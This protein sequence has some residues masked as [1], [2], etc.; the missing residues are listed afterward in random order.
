MQ[1][2]TTADLSPFMVR[3]VAFAFGAIWGSFFNVAIHRWPRGLSVVTPASHCPACNGRIP[4]HLNIPI[5]SFI[6]LRGKTACCG[7]R[8][9]PRYL[10]VEFTSAILCMS[11]V[12]VYF[13]NAP[14]TTTFIDALV[15]S[16]C[17]FTFVGGL[18]IVTFVDLEFMEI[19][20]E[21][22]LPIT[23]VGLVT[24]TYR[25]SPGV[26]AV[27]LGAGGSYLFVQLIFVWCYERLTGR[28]GM[29]EGDSKLLMMIG[30]FMG[31]KGA[32]FSIMAGA[33]Q[34]LLVVLIS[35]LSGKR[36]TSERSDTTLETG[37]R[38]TSQPLVSEAVSQTPEEMP[39]YSE[40]PPKYIGHMKIPFGPFLA[41]SAIEYL[42]FGS[43]LLD[44]YLGLF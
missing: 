38:V 14:P 22:T 23:A 37:D 8:I 31:Y 44:R 33:T 9:S 1:E 30:A 16:L 12:E 18:L 39:I 4:P 41:L 36:L 43:F 15:L 42:F 29:G 40:P 3:L 32:L 17:Y 7:N 35:M 24:A 21:V 28:R 5:V 27:A 13:I 25:I 2:I 10:F 19:P 34:G 20:D 6:F 26:E 11:V